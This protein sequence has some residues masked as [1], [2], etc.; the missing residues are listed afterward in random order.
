MV[1]SGVMQADEADLSLLERLRGG[2][3]NALEALMG[4]YTARVYRLA[5]GITRSAED[6][7]EVVQDVFLTICRKS[8]SF[9]GRSALGALVH[10]PRDDRAHDGD[11]AQRRD[12][13]GSFHPSARRM[14]SMP[15]PTS[16]SSR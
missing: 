16:S 14:R 8:E 5:Y 9:E 11:G 12:D 4:Q 10:A 2:D 15:R 13:P 6:A 1:H 3:A 7:E